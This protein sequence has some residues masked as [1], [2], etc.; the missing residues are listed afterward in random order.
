MS[1]LVTRNVKCCRHGQ[2]EWLNISTKCQFIVFP[3]SAD[4]VGY[5][6]WVWLI[7]ALWLR[8]TQLAWYIW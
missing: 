5:K 3:E 4:L 8:G 6:C 2:L 1:Q 7:V